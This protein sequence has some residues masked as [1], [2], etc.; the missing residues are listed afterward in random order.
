MKWKVIVKNTFKNCELIYP[1]QQKKVAEIVDFLKD[2]EYVKK[3]IIFGSSVTE[4]CTINSD[5]DIYI[6][7]TKEI[8]VFRNKYF[9]FLYDLW[10]NFQ[11]D[12]SEKLYKEIM[13]KGV[14]V[15]EKCKNYGE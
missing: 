4:R 1:I 11:V 13:E 10:T 14:V 12:K 8:N 2:N 3:I 15:Y 9:D 5:V 7:L 6:E